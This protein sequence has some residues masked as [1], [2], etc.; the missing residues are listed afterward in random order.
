MLKDYIDSAFVYPWLQVAKLYESSGNLNFEA[1]RDSLNSG[2]NIINHCSH[3]TWGSIEVGPTSADQF[4]YGDMDQLYNG[5]Q[6][7]LFYTWACW[8][9]VITMVDCLAEH[10][11]NNPDGGGFAYIGNTFMGWYMPGDPLDGASPQMDLEFFRLLYDSSAYQLGE[12]FAKSKV[13]FI[14]IA[15]SSFMGFSYRHVIYCLIL[16]GDPTIEIWTNSPGDLHVSHSPFCVIG[17]TSFTVNVAEDGALVCLAQDGQV[18]GTGVSSGGQAVVNLNY[19]VNSFEDIFVTVTKHDYLRYQDTLTVRA[20]KSPYVIYHSHQINDYLGNDDGVVNPGETILAPITVKNVGLMTAFGVSGTLRED[21]V[22]IV[23]TDS[24]KSYGNIASNDTAVSLGEYAFEVDFW[25]P[26]SYIVE[27]EMVATDGLREWKSR[28][29]QKVIPHFVRGDVNNDGIV[30]SADLVYLIS[31]LFQGGPPPPIMQAADC[32]CDRTV[33]V[34]DYIFLEEYLFR[35]GPPP[36]C[37]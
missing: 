1:F 7:G 6:V 26:D 28:F 15:D 16:L 17:A 35:G 10:W 36:Y 22:N 25:C 21:D 12:A 29:Y 18:L 2:Q 11:I 34:G 19:P 8:T 33:N 23:V 9:A 13:P 5:D 24:V 3:G 27:F 4:T 31:Y 14:P 37:P 20:T 32:N 30:N